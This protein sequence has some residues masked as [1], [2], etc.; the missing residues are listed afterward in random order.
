MVEIE[1]NTTPVAL[2]T[3]LWSS[4]FFW[5]R[6]VSI[7][8]HWFWNIKIVFKIKL[9]RIAGSI[10][11]TYPHQQ[12]SNTFCPKHLAVIWTFELVS[13]ISFKHN[14]GS[15]FYLFCML[16]ILNKNFDGGRICRLLFC[17]KG[18]IQAIYLHAYSL[19]L[20]LVVT[21]GKG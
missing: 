5:V 8:L 10:F 14:F 21:V 4:N 18:D 12:I 16:K 15:V 7:L 2:I 11:I 6:I 9:K 20:L 3:A 17:S 19:K 13:G 1:I